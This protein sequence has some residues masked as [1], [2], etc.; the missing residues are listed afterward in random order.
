MNPRSILRI[1][2]WET[3]R[4]AGDVDRKTAVAFVVVLVLL[5]ALVPALVAYGPT[6]GEGIYRVG[7]DDDSRYRPVVAAEPSLV[8]AGDPTAEALEDGRVD[9][10]VAGDQFGARDTAKG[11][12]ALSAFRSAVVDYNDALMAQE[13]NQSA[14]FP[15]VVTLTYA[16]QNVSLAG[17]QTGDGTDGGTATGD[18]TDGGTGGDGT[19]GGTGG[20]G[21]DASDG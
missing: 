6:P 21:T 4:S 8:A 17:A 18:Q 19:G 14:A 1:A 7:I 10:V 13:A 20:D 9:V 16:E 15:V 3:T 12:A 5:A 2:K 11:R